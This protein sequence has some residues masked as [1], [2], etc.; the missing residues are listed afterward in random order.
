[1]SVDTD[2]RLP[3]DPYEGIQGR[4]SADYILRNTHQQLVAL[5][6]QADLK[7]NILITVCSILLSVIAT[8]IGSDELRPGLIT[9]MV[10]LFLALLSAIMAILPKFRVHPTRVL[11]SDRDLL[12]FG[13]FARVPREQYV[14]EMG[15]LLREDASVYRALVVNIHNQGRYLLGAK[16]RWLT[17]GYLFFLTGFLVGGGVLLGDVLAS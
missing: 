15:E 13:H 16:Y 10:F 12:F 1:V 11:P 5:S 14:S 8:R 2:P 4:G 9:L 6:S 17:V 7:A 3:F